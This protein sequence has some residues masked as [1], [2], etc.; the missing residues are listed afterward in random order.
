MLGFVA[1]CG[2]ALVW[3][4][5]GYSLAVCMSFSLQW[6]LLLQTVVSRARR[7]HSC[8]AKV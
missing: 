8:D 6:L 4:S 5:R 1:A 7:L 3:A 2:L